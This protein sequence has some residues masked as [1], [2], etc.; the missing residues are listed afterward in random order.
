MSKLKNTMSTLETSEMGPK[1]PDHQLVPVL[2]FPSL[3][4]PR[5]AGPDLG[6]QQVGQSWGGLFSWALRQSVGG[7]KGRCPPYKEKEETAPFSF[8]CNHV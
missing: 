7:F 1:D 2:S 4:L 6:S 5:G 8:A 3:G